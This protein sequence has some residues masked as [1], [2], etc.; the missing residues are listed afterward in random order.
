MGVS[1]LTS[2]LPR[3]IN[4]PP[5]HFP[6]APLPP[7][8]CG[9]MPLWS[10]SAP[11][12][13]CRAPSPPPPPPPWTSFWRSH[14]RLR[15]L[16][17]KR[18]A[19]AQHLTAVPLAVFLAVHLA[20]P[21]VVPLLGAEGGDAVMMVGRE[22]YQSPLTEPLLFLSLGLH[23]LSGLLRRL[24][25]LPAAPPSLAHML[26]YPLIALLLLHVDANRA[27]APRLG[28]ASFAF[29]R[30]GIR[31]WPLSAGGVYVGIVAVGV[32]HALGAG[33]AGWARR[34]GARAQGV[35]GARAEAEGTGRGRGKGKGREWEGA[36]TVLGLGVAGW[37]GGV[38]LACL[39]LGRAGPA[40]RDTAYL[41]A[42][43]GSV[44]YN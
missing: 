6:L 39:Y 10:P 14:S 23:T 2:V 37:V 25:L 19:D 42:W 26:A 18:L 1:T 33:R 34:F 5:S 17:L 40:W 7:P 36:W 21:A 22:L 13:S 27:H 8:P 38:S 24:L 41:D 4:Q 29:V 32:G 9:T 16:L 28:G 12:S 15:L 43:R 35:E 31:R 20:A 3:T 30:A 44:F 11:S